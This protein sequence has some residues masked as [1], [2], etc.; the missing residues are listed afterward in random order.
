M[1]ALCLKG[2]HCCS[3]WALCP[4]APGCRSPWQESTHRFVLGEFQGT[5]GSGHSIPCPFPLNCNSLETRGVTHKGCWEKDAAVRLPWV[6]AA[7]GATHQGV[8]QC[9]VPLLQPGL[10]FSA[11]PQEP[12]S[13]LC[14]PP[15]KQANFG[16]WRNGLCF[17]RWMK[18]V[19]WS[20]WASVKP[21]SF[22]AFLLELRFF[23]TN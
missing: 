7:P 16:Q 22:A 3:C 6:R 13:L 9:F 18:A 14:L 20:V 10:P 11:C 4:R 15:L 1:P 21:L 8:P 2:F 17:C 12:H 19:E 5:L 23:R